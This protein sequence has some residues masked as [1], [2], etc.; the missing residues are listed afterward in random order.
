M[1]SCVPHESICLVLLAGGVGSR[2]KAVS[3][4]PKQ[5]YPLTED[6]NILDLIF[7][8]I[9]DGLKSVNHGDIPIFVVTGHYGSEIRKYCQKITEPKHTLVQERKPRGTGRALYKVKKKFEFS[10]Y[11]VINSDTLIEKPFIEILEKSLIAERSTMFCS[12]SREVAGKSVVSESGNKV[13]KISKSKDCDFKGHFLCY[14]HIGVSLLLRAD[15]SN[16]DSLEDDNLTRLA[17]AGKLDLSA[18]D[19]D[20][21]DMGTPK[22]LSDL[23]FRLRNDIK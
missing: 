3:N 11:L 19:T 14:T 13:T 6:A 7:R 1:V 20:V 21:F 17:T 8:W 15:I 10:K 23:V 9:S 16:T 18:L 5:L 12:R 2:F 22:G 4:L